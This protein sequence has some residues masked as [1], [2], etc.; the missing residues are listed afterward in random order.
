MVHGP[1]LECRG[2]E[3]SPW[4]SQPHPDHPALP[5][6]GLAPIWEVAQALG[7]ARALEEDSLQVSRYMLLP[8]FQLFCL[9]CQE[10]YAF[11]SLL[12]YFQSDL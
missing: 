4:R 12:H 10:S 6:I 2:S 8:Y 1:E 5:N 7:T 3:S 11:F 9:V